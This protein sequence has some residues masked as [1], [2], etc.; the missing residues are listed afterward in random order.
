VPCDLIAKTKDIAKEYWYNIIDIKGGF[1]ARYILELS[2]PIIGNTDHVSSIQCQ[3]KFNTL[4]GILTA[5]SVYLYF[6]YLFSVSLKDNRSE[7]LKITGKDATTLYVEKN[8]DKYKIILLAIL[9]STYFIFNPASVYAIAYLIQR[10][11]LT[12]TLFSVLALLVYMIGLNAKWIVV[13]I[14]LFIASLFLFKAAFMGKEHCIVLPAVMFVHYL[15]FWDKIKYSKIKYLI[16]GLLFYGL[17]SYL[18][19]HYIGFTRGPLDEPHN[20]EALT[21]FKSYT[22]LDLS[23][24]LQFWS[25]LTQCKF[26]FIYLLKWLFPLGL[27]IDLKYPIIS[28]I[29][30]IYWFV[31][32]ALYPII[33]LSLLFNKER[34]KSLMGLGL[35]I[36]YVF[37][38]VEVGTY[39]R[40][41]EQFV[42]YRSYPWMIGFF[43]FIPFLF[44]NIRAK[45]LLIFT[46]LFVGLLCY[47]YKERL[48]TFESDK[49]V[50]AD[51][52]EK[53]PTN[54]LDRVWG[55]QH[56]LNSLG[57]ACWDEGDIGCAFDYLSQAVDLDPNYFSALSNKALV[58]EAKNDLPQ[59]KDLLLKAKALS[60][61]SAVLINLGSVEWHL[62]NLNAA[63]EYFKQTLNTENGIYAKYNLAKLYYTVKDCARSVA[64]AKEIV[65]DYPL[66]NNFIKACEG[67]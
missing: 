32:Y 41:S 66:A 23:L 58:L 39:S 6:L 10:T 67:K 49:A 44:K 38:W 54:K 14:P 1:R 63:E 9:A 28:S 47:G 62:G 59:A 45:E 35:L 21:L 57:K 29:N 17:I 37:N 7:W 20:V 2:K 56:T 5:I 60:N 25:S 31:L 8:R 53:L 40:I 15:F 4:L 65:A 61:N 27:S 24:N 22:G 64:L 30:Q 48:N 18:F 42:L 34:E 19:F 33:A 26:Y 55:S 46:L 52:V 51:A 36:P 13:R 50:W 12:A 16:E 43:S 11:I 3:R